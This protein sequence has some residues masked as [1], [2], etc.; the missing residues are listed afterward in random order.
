MA[1]SILLIGLG[2]V[3]YDLRGMAVPLAVTGVVGKIRVLGRDKGIGLRILTF[4]LVWELLQF[5]GAV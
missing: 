4:G 2:A 3:G 1:V 5:C